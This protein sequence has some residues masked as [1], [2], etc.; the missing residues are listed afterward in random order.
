M[1]GEPRLGEAFLLLHLTLGQWCTSAIQKALQSTPHHLSL[2]NNGHGLLSNSSKDFQANRIQLLRLCSIRV[3]LRLHILLC[4]FSQVWKSFFMSLPCG[5]K[6][7]NRVKVWD[8]FVP[9][10]SSEDFEILWVPV[11]FLSARLCG[12]I[13]PDLLPPHFGTEKRTLGHTKKGSVWNKNS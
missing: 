10:F 6:R 5:W 2:N 4:V 1:P 13:N 9:S 3:D 8:L 12:H 7:T 11:H